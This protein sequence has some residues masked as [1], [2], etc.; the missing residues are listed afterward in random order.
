MYVSNYMDYKD[1]KLKKENYILLI[2]NH[3]EPEKSD[4]WCVNKI[5]FLVEFAF[6]YFNNCILSDAD[7]AAIDHGPVLD[8]YKNIFKIMEG[9]GL[10]KTE[11][12]KIRLISSDTVDIPQETKDIIIPLIKK[13]SQMTQGELKALTHSTDSYKITTKNERVMGNII[14]KKLAFLETF[15]DDSHDDDSQDCSI[16]VDIDRKNLIKI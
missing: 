6:I 3:L 2:L 11:G 16:L 9:K 5:A 7:Y 4:F 14:D 12:F 1:I 10:I 15:F 13:Y 8:N